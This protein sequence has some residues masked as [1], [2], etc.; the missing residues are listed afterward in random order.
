M[1]LCLKSLRNTLAPL[2]DAMTSSLS[3][4]RR[5]G[6][7]VYADNDATFVGVG[8]CQTFT[9]TPLDL[10]YKWES[11][12]LDPSAMGKRYINNDTLPAIKAIVESELKKAASAQGP[13]AEPGLRKTRGAPPVGMLGLGSRMNM[14][15]SGVGLVDTAAT[16]RSQ[17]PTA[18]S[19]GFPKTGT[20][21]VAFEYLDIEEVSQDKRNCTCHIV[22]GWRPVSQ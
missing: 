21:R 22:C 9:V 15:L 19:T 16:S 2:L 10:Y 1:L 11:I 7:F 4:V 8:L 14:K 6:S 13:K 3:V 12:V 5:R 18:R 17:F 20:S